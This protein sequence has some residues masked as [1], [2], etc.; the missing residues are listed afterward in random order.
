[1]NPDATCAGSTR[2]AD[3][4]HNPPECIGQT[5]GSSAELTTREMD[6]PMKTSVSAW[7][8]SRNHPA[9]S[10]DAPRPSEDTGDAT[11][12]N[13]HH[14]DAPTELPDMPKGTRGQGGEV[15][16]EMS[17]LGTSR[18]CGGG[19]GDEGSN[20]RRPGKPTEPPDEPQLELRDCRDV[21][22]DPGGETGQVE[23]NECA[24]H[25]IADTGDDKEA[26]EE[27]LQGAQ[28]DGESTTA[29]QNVSIMGERWCAAHRAHGRLTTAAADKEN[30]QR[31]ETIDDNVPETPPEPPPPLIDP[32]G[33]STRENRPPSIELEGERRLSAS[34]NEPTQAETN[35]LGV[36]GH[37]EDP[38]N[39]PKK[40]WTTLEQVPARSDQSEEGDSPRRPPDDP[41]DPSGE[42]SMTD[43]VQ[44]HRGRPRAD[45]DCAV[46]ETDGSCR[47][48]R[49]GGH[50]GD[51]E[52][53]RS[54]KVDS[55]GQKVIGHAEYD[56]VHT[57][58]NGN[59]RAIKTDTL[60]PVK[61]PGGPHQETCVFAKATKLT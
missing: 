22:V 21:Q 3:E 2:P 55:R 50:R 58:S 27:A 32:A 51:L 7:S 13:E 8:A 46:E 14:P 9:M 59:V 38:R 29:C 53:S 18:E 26:A 17:V 15:Q 49:S 20:K 42:V 54:V 40:L 19:T 25:G 11:G 6:Q 48:T 4:P 36:S 35:T 37:A 57:M 43:D 28:V 23:R 39:R 31:A 44:S 30:N 47:G 45:R 24:A 41:D 33:S 34:F 60:H 1:V 10:T 52:R 56:G 61:D 12:D 5:S 16:V